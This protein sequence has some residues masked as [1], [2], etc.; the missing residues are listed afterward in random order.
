MKE[1]FLNIPSIHE[2]SSSGSEV[3][4]PIET[5]QE[6]KSLGKNESWELLGKLLNIDHQI[7]LDDSIDNEKQQKTINWYYGESHKIF[8][9]CS[10]R[11]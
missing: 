4:L 11:E 2:F 5:L 9:T 1:I 3:Y 8:S 7:L 10:P 6:I